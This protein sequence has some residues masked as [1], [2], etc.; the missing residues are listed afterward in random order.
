MDYDSLTNIL[1]Q[2]WLHTGQ[3]TRPGYRQG[4]QKQ[5]RKSAVFLKLTDDVCLVINP[6]DQEKAS[7][8]F[9]IRSPSIA[10]DRV[11][12]YVAPH[13]HPLPAGCVVSQVP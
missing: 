10:H 2:I 5:V 8:E 12:A 1:A 13:P 11:S 7:L 6:A 3:G 4:S 9:R